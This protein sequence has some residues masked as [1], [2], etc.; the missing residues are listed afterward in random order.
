VIVNDVYA[1]VNKSAKQQI[2]A[3]EPKAA[4]DEPPPPLPSR[5]NFE[6]DDEVKKS[7]EDLTKEEPQQ[8]KTSKGSGIMSTI[9]KHIRQKS[10]GGQTKKIT[11]KSKEHVV[12][13]NASNEALN[14]KPNPPIKAYLV[15]DIVAPSSTKVVAP[16]STQMFGEPEMYESVTDGREEEIL[17]TGATDLPDGWQEVKDS[18]ETY[19]WHVAS[20]TT[21][22][23][24]P[25][26]NKYH[27]SN[28]VST[29]DVLISLRTINSRVQMSP[30]CS[31]FCLLS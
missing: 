21:Q 19:Y 6:A 20:G 12:K 16:P 26:V 23:E 8:E 9:K 5:P 18:G 15:T 3:D 24:K 28:P 1:V 29:L 11:E 4:E 22:W 17:P 10:D 14:E 30:I 2:L 25:K 13:K 27:I 7:Q 31:V